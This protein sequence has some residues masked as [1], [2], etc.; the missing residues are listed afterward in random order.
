MRATLTTIL[1]LA[2]CGSCKDKRMA[3]EKW[4]SD[5]NYPAGTD[6][7]SAQ[8]TKVAPSGAEIEAGHTPGVP[9]PAETENWWKNRAD[10]LLE[11]LRASGRFNVVHRNWSN[12]AEQVGYTTAGGGTAAGFLV[13]DSTLI[14][15]GH[16]RLRVGANADVAAGRIGGVMMP[17]IF[18][19]HLQVLEFAVDST[20]FDGAG[21]TDGDGF[22]G[23]MEI[24][25]YDNSKGG[26]FFY[27][28]GSDANWKVFVNATTPGPPT[29][30]DTG[31]VA[32]GLQ[33][34][35]I[36]WAGADYAGGPYVKFYID[37]VLVHTAT[38]NLP[39]NNAEYMYVAFDLIGLGPDDAVV[40]VGPFTWRQALTVADG[41]ILL[42]L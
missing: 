19:S 22:F 3:N 38:A 37:G 15:G 12:N 5:D 8:P 10:G 18:D 29:T 9:V 7:W 13:S 16:L 21:T 41:E 17:P 28:N 39:N 35:K 26:V 25:A 2:L 11:Y 34:M 4:A 24:G 30:T 31:V 14:Q 40:Y 27:K 36:V 42:R 1:L 6:P 20:S 23:L 33:Q 32:A